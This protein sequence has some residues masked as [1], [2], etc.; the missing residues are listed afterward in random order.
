[1]EHRA[2]ELRTL[3]RLENARIDADATEAVVVSFLLKKK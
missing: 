1:V 3:I 2:R